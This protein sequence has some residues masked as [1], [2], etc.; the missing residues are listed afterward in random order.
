MKILTT[1]IVL[2]LFAALIAVTSGQAAVPQTI[3]YQGRLLQPNGNPATGPV[4]LTCAIYGDSVSGT[5]LWQ[6]TRNN[7]T[8]N[9]DGTFT[10]LFGSIVP[11]AD[12]V[13]ASAS[14]WLGITV[15]GD[16][17][18][19]PRTRLS[20]VGYAYRVATINGAKGGTISDSLTVTGTINIISGGV[21][22]PDGTIQFTQA[23]ASNGLP[24]GGGTMT[25]PIVSVGNPPITMGKANFGAGNANTG[26]SAFVVGE[27]DTASG[28]Y[29]TVAGGYGNNATG[30]NTDTT[31]SD[32][33]YDTT[34]TGL[35]RFMPTQPPT[36]AF[37]F[38]GGGLDNRA[39]GVVSVVCGGKENWA[40]Y[41]GGAVLG[42][43]K[44][45]ALRTYGVI[46]GG[47]YNQ[48]Q[49]EKSFI[50]GGYHNRAYRH[51]TTIG[52][53]WYNRAGDPQSLSGY[54]ST[55]GGG[56]GNDAYGDSSTIAGGSHNAIAA[57][58]VGA[59]IGGGVHNSAFGNYAT[60]PGGT[61]NSA[62]GIASFAI[63]QRAKAQYDN[64]F[65]WN[66]GTASDFASTGANQFLIRASGNV[67][68]GTDEPSSALD[69]AG[70]VT[71]TGFKMPTDPPPQNGY[72]LTTN[73]DGV[74]NW[75]SA[76]GGGPNGWV[77]DGAVVR[78]GTISDYVGIGTTSPAAKLHI[79]SS[80]TDVP[81]RV[82]GGNQTF[83]E[84]T[85]TA[86]A[87][88][89]SLY[90]PDQT[91]NNGVSLNF[92]GD[93]G[94]TPSQLFGEIVA[95]YTS[96]SPMS[97]DIVF[98]AR[99]N[100]GW[101]EQLRMVSN[102]NVGIGTATPANRLDVEGGAVVGATYSGTNAAPTN[103]LL[104]EGNVG[105]GTSTPTEALH[106]VGNIRI[107]DGAAAAGY[108]LTASDA[109]G[110]ASWQ[111]ASGG[112]AFLPLAG[113]TMTGAI[114]SVGS[115]S[116]TMGK[117]NF[118]L[119]N[120]NAGTSAFVAGSNNIASANHSCVS[121]GQANY[122]TG[123]YAA[124]GGGNSNRAGGT[125]SSIGGGS[126]NIAN[127]TN[128]TVGG[129]FYNRASGAFSVVAGGGGAT[130]ADSNAAVGD[131]SVVGGGIANIASGAYSTVPGGRSNTA[132]G[133]Y[134]FAAGYAAKANHGGAFVWADNSGFDFT[135]SAAKEFAA[136]ATG[137]VRFVTG[138]DGS[139]APNA[140]VQVAAGGTSW[141]AICDR[142]LKENFA[143]VDAQELLEKVAS[144]PVR[145]WNA[146]AQPKSTRHIGPVAQDFYALFG[147]G[148]D[149][150]H[151]T[152]VDADGVALAAIQ[153]LYD[154]NKGQE[155]RI[156]SLEEHVEALQ[157]QVEAMLSARK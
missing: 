113:G 141:S 118:G 90:N 93:V 140:G 130:I 88:L 108:V 86:I 125:S 19:S 132:Q 10:L 112:G 117:G 157:K 149:S 82:A 152:T 43:Y 27:A 61:D 78:L 46:V 67:G 68:I 150:T 38:I 25:G 24:E 146:K 153:A 109:T 139:G 3:S 106:V 56:R 101:N 111:A 18:L 22:F 91:N 145:T 16:A 79:I 104:V 57:G 5:P 14:R 73:G 23:G 31:T 50:G 39:D 26:V 76:G 87:N 100:G 53:G 119:S 151:I 63:G 17:E 107:D 127:G 144:L 92:R 156:H 49:G 122:A 114:T 48:S 59:S 124:I 35:E 47:Y 81:L 29:S 15:D 129:G 89:L 80:A 103:G 6:E 98:N 58:A 105:I 96:H 148:E 45:Q 138:I 41:P 9:T 133:D 128:S 99:H 65:V 11:I 55:I 52:G 147:V 154:K 74:G 62:V 32:G 69:V 20:S 44:N 40:R 97:T 75:Q 37:A 102:G 134:S 8:I 120:T 94:G 123:I 115:P 83:L 142:N 21:K 60:V 136:R 95:Q 84:R 54:Y 131:Y 1:A 155:K 42:G 64:S 33:I 7:I 72:V 2:G 51:L 12:S 70:M 71:M 13:F 28:D 121:G 4:N 30:E 126:Y 137:G 66:D 143:V 34:E 116:I 110:L 36:G 85:G 135:S 77:D